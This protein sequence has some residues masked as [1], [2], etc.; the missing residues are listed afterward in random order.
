MHAKKSPDCHEGTAGSTA[1]VSGERETEKSLRDCLYLLRNYI[2]NH[3]QNIS[4]NMGFKGHSSEVSDGN[5]EH[6]IENWKKKDLVIK[7]ERTW[8]TVVL[9]FCA[10]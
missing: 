2:N 8:L 1:G 5:E 7:C 6:A 4:G 10:R 3:Q 9:V